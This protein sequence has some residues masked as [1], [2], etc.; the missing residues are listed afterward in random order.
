[1]LLC[2]FVIGCDDMQKPARR[3]MVKIVLTLFAL[4]YLPILISLIGCGSGPN[5]LISGA[6]VEDV[7]IYVSETKREKDGQKLFPVFGIVRLLFW[8]ECAGYHDTEWLVENSDP[9]IWR[10]GDIISIRITELDHVG[11]ECFT[12]EH[13]YDHAIFIGLCFPGDYT[14]RVNDVDIMFTVGTF[15]N[16]LEVKIYSLSTA[17]VYTTATS[18][19]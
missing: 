14:L 4:L 15:N 18:R 11:S 1:M 9:P 3:I 19:P 12:A 10:D 16:D 6:H 7:E 2:V 17:G 8:D 13:Y 5:E